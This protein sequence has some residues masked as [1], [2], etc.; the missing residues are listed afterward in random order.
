[1]NRLQKLFV[2]NEKQREKLLSVF[3]TAGYP[4]LECTPELVCAV[5]EAGADF[6]EIGLP[7]SDPI[8]DGP[9]IQQSSQVA[10]ENGMNLSR[11]LEQV[12][13][14]RQLSE[15]PIVLMG[16]FNPILKYGLEK[17]VE[18]ASAAELDGCI[19]P[20][21]IPEEYLK[22]EQPFREKSLGVNFLIS[23][24]T[25][26]TRIRS[27][28]NLTHAFVYCV[29]VTGITG[30]RQGVPPGIIDFLR[31]LKGMVE[32]PYLVGFGISNSDDAA[33][34]ARHCD[35]VIVG[36]AIMKILS[37]KVNHKEKLKLVS[38]FVGDLKSS[39]NPESE[40]KHRAF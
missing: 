23:P 1:M 3:V 12:Q 24:N 22:F 17:F 30:A 31:S 39:L 7:F 29:S 28:A 13:T 20:D 40:I 33:E 16:Y 14:I 15:I 35:G 36:S 27:I 25:S 37:R 34:I 10:I 32:R 5:A 2:K 8:A 4:H 9:T 11:V 26:K 21:L 19:I 38:Q 18:D 6:V